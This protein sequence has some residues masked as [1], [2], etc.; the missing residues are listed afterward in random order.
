MYQFLILSFFVTKFVLIIHANIN[1]KMITHK[2]FCGV[3][4]NNP[5]L[6]GELVKKLAASRKLQS[7]EHALINESVTLR[8]SFAMIETL[9]EG[10]YKDADIFENE[11]ATN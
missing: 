2:K 4:L 10:G 5:N 8:R 3:I 7:I 1:K 9:R 11:S 6:L